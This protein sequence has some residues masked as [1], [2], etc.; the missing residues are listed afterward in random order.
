MKRPLTLKDREARRL[1]AVERVNQGYSQ[2]TVAE[3]LGVTPRAVRSWMK[4][5]REAG[6][7][8]L[9]SPG[10]PGRP[11]KLTPDQA[12]E[13][14][15]WFRQSPTAFGYSTHLWTG[16]RVAALIRERFGVTYNPRYL[17]RWLSNRGISSQRPQRVPQER[18][19]ARIDAWV[20]DHWPRI[21]KKGAPS[22]L[23][24]F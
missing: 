2:T 10:H 6:H 8:G 24:S 12:A 21:V 22:A 5:F 14:L 4:S 15:S 20:R 17:I 1:L 3:F 16:A 19:P 7:A 23:T 13:V 9:L 11:D 18:Q